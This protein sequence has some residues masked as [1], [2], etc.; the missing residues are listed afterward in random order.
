MRACALQLLKVG[1]TSL[2]LRGCSALSD[3]R[4]WIVGVGHTSLL[5]LP[6]HLSQVLAFLSISYQ[7]DLT[8]ALASRVPVNP[9]TTPRLTPA[10][11]NYKI[12]ERIPAHLGAS[13]SLRWVGGGALQHFPLSQ[14]KLGLHGPYTL[15]DWT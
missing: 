13:R 14:I 7:L 15:Q 1:S 2:R 5:C 8:L 3:F 4:P 9:K 10:L 12:L 11:W 6:T